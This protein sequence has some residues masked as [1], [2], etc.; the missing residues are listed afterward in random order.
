MVLAIRC[1]VYARFTGFRY[2]NS[3]VGLGPEEMHFNTRDELSS[4]NP[5]SRY[6]IL[7]PEVVESYFYLWR[8]TKDPKYR[9]WA[10]DMVQ[11][12]KNSPKKKT[13]AWFA[14]PPRRTPRTHAQAPLCLS[15][16]R[17]PT[18]HA[19]FSQCPRL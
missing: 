12:F 6:Y 18:R 19:G 13:G 4:P 11:V 5:G 8:T 9:E 7:R 2:V 10:W 15:C 17:P 3:P 1:C 14:P 16:I